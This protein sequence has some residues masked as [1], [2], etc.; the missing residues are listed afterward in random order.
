MNANLDSCSE[1]YIN[2]SKLADGCK[3]EKCNTACFLFECGQR[4]F[5]TRM[6]RIDKLP[7]EERAGELRAK[8]QEYVKADN[9]R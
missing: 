6:S 2:R 7:Y 3:P 9:E 4:D 5:D 1:Y 8:A